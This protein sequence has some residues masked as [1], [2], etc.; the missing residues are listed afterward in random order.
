MSRKVVIK[1]GEWGIVTKA[2]GSSTT[3]NILVK[4]I[5]NNFFYL[6]CAALRRSGVKGSSQIS[7]R[8]LNGEEMLALIIIIIKGSHRK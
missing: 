5:Y 8:L 1:D 2:R 6:G 7:G 3:T 4:K